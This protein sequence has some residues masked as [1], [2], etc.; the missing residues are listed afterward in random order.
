ME[1]NKKALRRTGAAAMVAALAAL[2]GCRPNIPGVPFI[3][4]DRQAFAA[5]RTSDATPPDRSLRATQAHP[6][7][8]LAAARSRP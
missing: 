2:T 8:A 6:R 3:Q 7:T 1:L 4:A 5:P